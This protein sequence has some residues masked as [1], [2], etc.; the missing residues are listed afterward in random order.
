MKSKLKKNKCQ[1]LMQKHL[2]EY[3]QFSSQ[4]EPARQKLGDGLSEVKLVVYVL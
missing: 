3:F 1:I 4:L 2:S